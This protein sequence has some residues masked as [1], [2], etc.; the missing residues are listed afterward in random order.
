MGHLDRKKPMFGDKVKQNSQNETSYLHKNQQSLYF[1]KIH[2][3]VNIQYL[4]EFASEISTIITL[5][6]LLFRS[7]SAYT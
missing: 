7:P 6:A 3:I 2:G 4:H 5:S 1:P